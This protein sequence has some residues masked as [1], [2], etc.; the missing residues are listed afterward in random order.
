MNI[1]NL[2]EGKEALEFASNMKG[3]FDIC[4]VGNLMY[5]A[6]EAM[7]A[8]I[9]GKVYFDKGKLAER[10]KSMANTNKAV[11]ESHDCKK[12]IPRQG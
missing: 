8:K 9:N 10:L 1:N 5:Y 11:P 4:S 2:I 3:G 7:V 6:R 12:A